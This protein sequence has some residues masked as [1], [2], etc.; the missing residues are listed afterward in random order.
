MFVDW[1]EKDGGTGIRARVKRITTAYANHYTIPPV[2]LQFMK[3]LGVKQMLCVNTGE[4]L[5]PRQK[6]ADA[7]VSEIHEHV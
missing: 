4:H 3:I 2:T 6:S 7:L 1:F 5:K